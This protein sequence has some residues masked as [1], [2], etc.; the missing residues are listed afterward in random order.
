MNYRIEATA[1][2][3]KDLKNLK[4]KYPSIKTDLFN[5]QHDLLVNPFLGEPLGKDCFKIRL[6]ISSKGKGKR[7][8]GRV[9]TC[10]KVMNEKIYLLAL[11]DKS[12][13]ETI[14]DKELDDMLKEAGLL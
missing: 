11:Y 3:I 14:S 2:F 8:G 10:V 7:G 4:R 6:K 1:H 5:L 13:K 12:E 9:L